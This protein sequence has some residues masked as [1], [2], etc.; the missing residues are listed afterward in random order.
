MR[1][2]LLLVFV[3]AIA[4]VGWRWWQSTREWREL[5]HAI[6]TD[7][8]LS[9]TEKRLYTHLIYDD[10]MS[11]LVAT[12]GLRRYYKNQIDFNSLFL[13]WENSCSDRHVFVFSPV[14]RSNHTV[15][16]IVLT[17]SEFRPLDY[18]NANCRGQ[19][20]SASVQ[21]V[22]GKMELCILAN[23][24]GRH[25]HDKSRGKYQYILGDKIRPEPVEWVRRE[26]PPD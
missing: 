14:L 2:L 17:D 9:A 25:S 18:A 15:A 5:R 8:R 19:L 3:A 13:T 22:D 10:Q 12:I 23:T 24:A 1:F 26:T 20:D 11:E 7:K 16:L 21:S 4:C 6:Q